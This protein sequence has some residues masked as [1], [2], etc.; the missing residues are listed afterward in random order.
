MNLLDC[1]ETGA[2]TA[3]RAAY[4]NLHEDIAGR[5]GGSV[6]PYERDKDSGQKVDST[7]ELDKAVT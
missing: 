5:A 7:M 2:S 6:G 1:V 4:N 3:A